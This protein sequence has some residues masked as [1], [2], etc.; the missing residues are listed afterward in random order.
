MSLEGEPY[1]LDLATIPDCPSYL[2][3][4]VPHGVVDNRLAAHALALMQ[5]FMP[6]AY[7]SIRYARRNDCI[8]TMPNWQRVR[9]AL[10]ANS[11]NAA[12][13]PAASQNV[14][15]DRMRRAIAV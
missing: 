14:A 3:D 13:D 11:G 12:F 5:R 8:C 9:P 7:G 4:S 15:P 10:A 1:Y 6:G 2:D